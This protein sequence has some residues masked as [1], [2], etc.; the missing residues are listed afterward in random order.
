MSHTLPLLGL[1]SSLSSRILST[2]EINIGHL[3]GEGPE[4]AVPGSELSSLTPSAY[5]LVH[6]SAPEGPRGLLRR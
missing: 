4:K 5:L 3:V 2:P 1:G 6:L